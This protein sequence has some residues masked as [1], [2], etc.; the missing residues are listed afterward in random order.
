MLKSFECKECG[1]IDERF[2]TLKKYEDKEYLEKKCKCGGEVFPIISS[3]SYVV[4]GDNSASTKRKG[5]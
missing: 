5:Q 1:K 2:I 4:K 3:F